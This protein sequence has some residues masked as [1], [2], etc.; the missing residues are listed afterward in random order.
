MNFFTDDVLWLFAAYVAGSAVT[1]WMVYK[2]Q[3]I[4]I[5]GKTIDSL[6][7]AG[8]IRHKKGADGEVELMQWN[9]KDE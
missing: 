1:G 6:C 5:V 8:F 4:D 2:S 7:E 3:T 9:A